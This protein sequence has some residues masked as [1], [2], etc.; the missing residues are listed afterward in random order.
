MRKGG[1]HRERAMTRG[2]VIKVKE[3]KKKETYCGDWGGCGTWQAA[4]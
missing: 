3:R 2:N 1:R 4:W